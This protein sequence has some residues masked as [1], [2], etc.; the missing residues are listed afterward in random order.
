MGY[1]LIVLGC[2][3]ADLGCCFAFGAWGLV[4]VGRCVLAV[5]CHFIVVL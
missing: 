5:G 2:F 3:F 1:G 4:L